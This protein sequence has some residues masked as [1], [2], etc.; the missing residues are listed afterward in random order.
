MTMTEV[1]IGSVTSTDGTTIGYH[2][3]GRGPGLVLLHGSMES[4][5]SHVQLAE[6]LANSFTVYLPDRRGRG[7]SGPY[8]KDYS[9]D[10]D[11]EDMAALLAETGA[12]NVFGV[13]SGAIIWLRAA[14][15][16]ST[17]HRAAILNRRCSS[18]PP[19]RWPFWRASTG[20]WPRAGSRRPSSRP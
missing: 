6:A 15:T 14:L 9:V 20:R 10:R 2:Q 18:T 13:S 1:K 19:R 3:L 7:L 4:A 17:I 11:V 5:Q 12:H 16:L 8:S